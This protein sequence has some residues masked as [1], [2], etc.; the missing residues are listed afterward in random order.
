MNTV[1]VDAAFDSG[2]IEVV[3][4]SSDGATLTIRADHQSKFKQWF[5]FRV[6]GKAGQPTTLKIE[7]MNSTAYPGGWPDYNARVSEDRAYW[8]AAETTF[9]KDAGDGTLTIR[10]TP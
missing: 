1:K 3:S 5:H 4:T 9:D 10:Y 7:G 2:N 8:A 6:C